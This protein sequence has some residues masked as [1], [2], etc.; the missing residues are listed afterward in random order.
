MRKPWSVTIG[1]AVVV[2]VAAGAVYL[3]IRHYEPDRARFPVRGIDVSHHQGT[4][5]WDA[6]VNDDIAFAWVKVS[7]GGDHRDRE[8]ERNI[9]EA[10]RVGLPVGIYH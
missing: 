1:A 8:F 3:Y 5:D 6:V 4:I 2:V 10:N 9:A 7:E